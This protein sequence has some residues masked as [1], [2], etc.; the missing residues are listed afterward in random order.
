MYPENAVLEK[1]AFQKYNISRQVFEYHLKKEGI[2]PEREAYIRESFN[3]QLRSTLGETQ[4]SETRV[5]DLSVEPSTC[6]AFHTGQSRSETPRS[7]C[8]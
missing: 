4:S 1:E 7:S 8:F 3:A 2:T 5:L 6:R